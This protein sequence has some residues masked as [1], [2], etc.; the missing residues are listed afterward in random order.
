MRMTFDVVADLCRLYPERVRRVAGA[1]HEIACH[2]W[3]HERPRDLAPAALEQM[4][5][6][7]IA[8]FGEIGLRPAG[9]R[10]PES[11]W[12]TRLVKRLAAYGYAWNA[13]R[14]ASPS[15]YRISGSLVRVPVRTDDWDL[16]DRSADGARVIGKWRDEVQDAVDSG[17]V[18]S[19]GMHEWIVGRD[20]EFASR[21]DAFLGELR[22]DER[23]ELKT[24]G[25][26]DATA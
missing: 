14:D 2:G 17:G 26:A 9:F 19:L 1:G 10:S 7:T 11:A 16:A 15:P 23:I 8:C 18:V 21:L 25:G 4:L 24:L 13:E 3:R 20:G 22:S 5:E 6:E 12:S